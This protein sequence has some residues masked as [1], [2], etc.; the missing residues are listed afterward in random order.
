MIIGGYGIGLLEGTQDITEGNNPFWWAIVTMTTVGY[1]DFSPMSPEGRLFAVVIMFAGISLIALLTATI[2]SVFVARKIREDKGLEKLNVTDHILL[3]GWNKNVDRIMDSLQSLSQGKKLQIVLINEASED[4]IAAIRNK[5]REIKFKF[6]RGDYTR[7]TI[8]ERANLK[9]AST[10]IVVPNDSLEAGSH[11]DEKTIFGTLTMK[12]LAPNIR[13]IAYITERENLTHIKRANA[14]EVILSDD[15]GA[16]MIASHVLDPGVPQTLSREEIRTMPQLGEDIYRAIGRL[17]GISGGDF[18]ARFN[19]RGGDHDQVLVT[20]DGLEL[21]EP[22]HL[23]DIAGGALSIVD[24]EVVG[25]V[26]LMTGGFPADYGD[27]QSAVLD[28]E[29]RTPGPGRR[30]SA[31]VGLTN[32]RVLAEG[33]TGDMD[34]LLSARR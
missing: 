32:I 22:F 8:L 26:D 28:M 10:A 11:P 15:L 21:Q 23:K 30:I 34:W 1:G 16:Y 2:S 12:T 33:G 24:L 31:G 6:V 14:D 25:G 18:S 7:E 3:C 13:V 29:S 5:Y 4:A 9:S 19:V 27:R 17:P 20:L